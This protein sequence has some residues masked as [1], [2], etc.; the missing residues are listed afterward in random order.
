MSRF[1]RT[2]PSLARYRG[3]LRAASDSS[4]ELSA[5]VTEAIDSARPRDI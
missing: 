1:G 5:V 2:A 3:R 4:A